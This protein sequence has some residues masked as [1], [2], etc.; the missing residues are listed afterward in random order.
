MHG[1]GVHVCASVLGSLLLSHALCACHPT[2]E[3]VSPKLVPGLGFQGQRSCPPSKSF[4]PPHRGAKRQVI[5][6]H[7]CRCVTALH[8]PAR[9]AAAVRLMGRWA[10]T[11]RAGP[12]WTWHGRCPRSPTRPSSGSLPGGTTPSCG[13]PTGCT[14]LGP[15][16]GA[17]VSPH[18]HLSILFACSNLIIIRWYL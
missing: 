12:L 7:A 8:P 14:A 11:S 4:T 2:P 15:G 5:T 16:P 1:R 3:A 18:L 17:G 6:R 9:L 13:A 10:M